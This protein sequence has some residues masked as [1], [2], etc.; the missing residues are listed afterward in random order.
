M[1]ETTEDG[2]EPVGLDVTHIRS[3]QESVIIRHLTDGLS[4][5]Q[6]ES[7][8]TLVTD[9][10]VVAP[11]DIA[12]EHGR[13]VESVR[14]ALRG[15]DDLVVREYAEVSLRSSYVAKLVH[16]AVQ[17]AEEAVKRAAE[18]GAKA[19]RAAEQ[20]M[21]ETM[22][23]FIAW[24]ARHGVDVDDAMNRRE[25]RMKLRFGE[26]GRE[27]RR[28]IR[29]GFRIWREADLPEERFRRAKIRFSDGGIADAWRYLNPG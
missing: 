22:S 16:D 3:T 2:P 21:E 12:D 10:G 9:G 7:L 11:A 15:I 8:Q 29:E 24:A 25:A 19:I 13:H 17:E 4:P 23:V 28:A 20:G 5:V 26:P 18:T 27:T 14:R 1:G 6:W